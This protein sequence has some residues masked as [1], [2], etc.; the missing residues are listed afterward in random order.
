MKGHGSF[1]PLNPNKEYM[2]VSLCVEIGTEGSIQHVYVLLNL[3]RDGWP[4]LCESEGVEASIKLHSLCQ[5]STE[6]FST[7][8][9]D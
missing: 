2:T 8:K 1:E 3:Q 6:H 4:I 9:Y 7:L 5:S